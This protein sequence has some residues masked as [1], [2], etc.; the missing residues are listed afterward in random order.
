MKN[1]VTTILVTVTIVVSLSVGVLAGF[2]PDTGQTKCYNN[3]VEI[4]CPQPGQP[5]YGQDAQYG[6]NTQS[7]TKLDENGND[8]PDSATEW[9]M[10][11]DNVTGLIWVKDG[12]LM[13]TR[14]PSFDND[15]TAGDGQ[16][17]WQHALDYVAKLN[18]ENYLDHSDWR[19]PNIKELSTLVDSSI[20]FPGP[21]I[22]TSYFQNPSAF[23]CVSWSSTTCADGSDFAFAWGVSFYFGGVGFF[24]TPDYYYVR[25]VRGGQSGSFDNFIDNGDGTV[26]DTDTGL[27]WQQAT[28]PG[29]YNWQQA[30]SYC[31]NLPLAGH[32][33]WRLPNRNELQS[34]VDYSRSY[35][36]ID[37]TYFPDPASWYWSSTTGANDSDGAWLVDFDGGSVGGSY[38][39]YGYYYVR[40][41]RGGDCGPLGTLV[42]SG[43]VRDSTTNIPLPG[44]TVDLSDGSSCVTDSNGHYSFSSLSAP[45][46]TVSVNRD[47]YM[48]YNKTI[49]CAD[50]NPHNI[51]LVPNQS[52][53]GVQNLS[54]YS[55][56]SVNTATGNYLYTEKDLELPGRGLSFVFE[57]HYNSQDDEDG[58]LGFGWTHTYNAACRVNSN[59]TV[60]IRWGDGKTETWTPDGSGGYTPQSGVFDSLTYNNNGVYTVTEKDSTKYNF[61]VYVSGRL[62]SIVDKNN[63]TISLT[64]TGRNLSQLTDTAGRNINFTYDG[65]NRI[66]TI[67]DPIGRTTRFAYDGNGDLVSATDMNGN[68]TTYTYDSNHQI[69]TMV[70]P[71]GNTVVTNTY[72]GQK[73]TTSSTDA[74]GGH[75]TYAYDE[76]GRKTTMT[77][78]L[79][80]TTIHYYD[81]LL[82]LIKE[83]DGL[84][85]STFYMY[86]A[87]GN[88]IETKDKKGNITTYT[89]DAKG[90]VLTKTDAL[91]NV[92]TITYDTNNNPLTRTDALGNTIT[93]QYDSNGNLIKTTDP[94]GNFTTVT[95][96]AYGEPVTVTDP[97]GTIT[98]NAYDAQG[99]LIEVTDEL[100]KKT[101]F[102]YDGAGRK[103]TAKDALNRITTYTYDNNDNQLTVTD[104][105]GNVVRF[106]YDGNDNK[107][108]ATDPK[109]NTTTYAYDAKDLLA[110]V[111][112]PMGKTISYAY[113]ALDRKT[114][115]TDKK[116]FTTVY[117]YD[118]VGNLIRVTDPLG[119]AENYTY[120]A[121]GNKLSA[122]DPL[123]NIV[124]YAYDA[125]N[126]VISSTDPLG[127]TS[128]TTYD[129]L[130][131][132]VLT[133]NA[134]SQTTGFEYDA[135]GR[136]KKVTD[137]NS[138]TVSYTYDQN[139]NRL[140][141]TD[142]NGK[143]TTYVY[144][145]L[146][147][148]IQRVEPLGSTNQYTYDAVGNRVSMTDAKG[149]TINYAYDADNKL[150]LMS[151]PDSSTV[152]YSYDANGNRIRMFDSL[153]TTTYSYDS[154]NR[155]T[156]YTNP[157]GKTIGYGYDANGNRQS[158]T[159]PDNKVVEYAYDSLNRLT[160]VTDWQSRATMYSYNAADWLMEIDNP[161][162]TKSTYTYDAAGRLTG[163]NNKK[164]NNTVISSY[165]Y[166]LDAIGNHNSSVN[167]EPLT[168]IY[169][170]SNIPYNYDAENRLTHAGGIDN[171]FDANGNMLSKDSNTFVYDFNDRLVQSNVGGEITQYAYDGDG[172]RLIKTDE[173][174]TVKYILDVNRSLS[175]VL[176]ETDGTGAIT[177]YYVY[178]EELIS[179]ILPDGTASYYHYDS[180]GST[181]ALTN[182]SQNVTDAYAYD[183]FGN[184]ANS[185]G[186][187]EN[188]FK[189]LGSHGVM[190]EGNGLNY[191]RERYYYPELGRFVTKDPLMGND[192]DTQSLNRYVY[193]LNNP[194]ILIDIDGLKSKKAKKQK[195]KNKKSSD[196]KN[197]HLVNKKSKNKQKQTGNDQPQYEFDPFWST[198]KVTKGG[199]NKYGQPHGGKGSFPQGQ[200][201]TYVADKYNITWTGNA[202]T[203]LKT[204][205]DKGYATGSGP[206]IG[207]IVV[208]KEGSVGH[209]AIVE[210]IRDGKII[211]SEANYDNKGIGTVGHGRKLSV[212][213]KRIKGYIYT[214]EDREPEGYAELL[215]KI[216]PY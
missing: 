15:G 6:P 196:K 184:V 95:Y 192:G 197:D 54:G 37:A 89:Y 152:T 38:K 190:D 27:M 68:I 182:I 122:T 105:L 9:V 91:N 195:T 211:L 161:N 168:K 81:D 47:E 100:G 150:I 121:N 66:T 199:D 174:V 158:L 30:L 59:A 48:D 64:Y 183:S 49:I 33:D 177:A 4:P 157:F 65:S 142:P 146:N 194:I 101:A 112:D 198:Q 144:D 31:E 134:K 73:R 60:T 131:R 120:D 108:T 98:T 35:Q 76:V 208:T 32:S 138:G 163:L 7:Y 88:R 178:G 58:P 2:V 180:R 148:I 75:T 82:R 84:G 28:A 167:N 86:D 204:A 202:G 209:V 17:T 55:Q 43:I 127:N 203:W 110:T 61:N 52:A 23:F 145:V 34:I 42:I 3:D 181:I 215:S 8:L 172:E 92:T 11:R 63:N 135:L 44:V 24:N 25:A 79:G 69:L 77:D 201:T 140:T 99:N 154:L 67:T 125:L 51:L 90:N 29:I 149:N 41:V 96:D 205:R 13:A 136:L 71:K 1:I 118:A 162:T 117:A 213:D 207:A 124:S 187:T 103:L 132:I 93:Y 143:I 212:S 141:T 94:L 18:N 87:L 102:T 80:Y 97:I 164:S 40:A 115:S 107:I 106:T 126:R 19:L 36:T 137:A 188:P 5:F 111:T 14:D 12:N 119:N 10:V 128:T 20:P 85:N 114:S 26:T 56:E 153:G 45:A 39:T 147:R 72:D 130:D 200:C 191:I 176:A 21:T 185:S 104:P 186:S 74:K 109:G 169:S 22:N 83:T 156:S 155:M 193:A 160:S 113:D 139:G 151:Y 210:D 165:S 133:T 206:A 16:V 170:N 116:G 46:Y 171:Y 179:K 50:Y 159:Y 166:T 78:A 216:S 214:E 123:G 70:D 62:E 57:R 189:Y 175:H 173:G 53:L 129:A